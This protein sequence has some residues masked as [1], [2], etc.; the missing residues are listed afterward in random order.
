MMA[1]LYQVTAPRVLVLAATDGVDSFTELDG[2][3]A[4]TTFERHSQLYAIV[5]GHNDNHNDV[6]LWN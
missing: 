3:Y 1:Q 4:V 6:N 5:A 2:A